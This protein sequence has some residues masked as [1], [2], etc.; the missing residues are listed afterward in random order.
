MIG[1][2]YLY[3]LS[4]Y[5]FICNFSYVIFIFFKIFRVGWV[6]LSE[7]SSLT[8]ALKILR[9]LKVIIPSPIDSAT[10]EPNSSISFRLQANFHNLKELSYLP[11]IFSQ[12]SRI[13]FDY[14]RAHE[15]AVLYDEE[16]N[17]PIKY[18]LDTLLSQFPNLPL[19]NKLDLIILYLRRVHFFVYYA[20]RR[21][22]DEAHLTAFSSSISF[23]K[24]IQ[25]SNNEETNEEEN[26]IDNIQID[27]DRGDNEHNENDNNNDN[28][29]HENQNE[30]QNENQQQQQDQ[31]Q[32]QI[33]D[34]DDKTH[35]DDQVIEGENEQEQEN[36]QENENET[37]KEQV[38]HDDKQEEQQ[39]QE[40][41]E[42]KEEEENDEHKNEYELDESN[43]GLFPLVDLEITYQSKLNS[44]SE[45]LDK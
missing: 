1:Y 13:Q 28:N 27:D 22:H 36:D 42:Q 25:Q 43:E 23:R 41:E 37:E 29:E 26:K 5:F 7:G 45:N 40:E 6:I 44:V 38:I 34:N 35:D 9:D 4:L 32:D 15:L 3:L 33:K 17:I 10:G 12:P 21:F 30:D 2:L 31:D 20:G 16:R 24:P 11:E 39:Q 8:T 18:N 14:D 19:V